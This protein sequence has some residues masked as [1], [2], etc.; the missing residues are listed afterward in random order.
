MKLWPAS[1]WTGTL[2]VTIVLSAAGAL[3]AGSDPRR[4]PASSTRR[5]RAT[6]RSWS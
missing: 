4:R 5:P 3:R 6:M 1:A 2:A